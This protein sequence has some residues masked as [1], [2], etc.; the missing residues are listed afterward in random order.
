MVCGLRD[1]DA[2]GTFPTLSAVTRILECVQQGELHA[3]EDLP[4]LRGQPR[5]GYRDVGRMLQVGV[6]R[7][8]PSHQDTL[9]TPATQ[10]K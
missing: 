6:R 9:R 10:S 1:A 2:A 3:A 4:P 5:E 7:P 8:F